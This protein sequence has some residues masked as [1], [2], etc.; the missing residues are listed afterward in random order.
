MK[1]TEVIPPAGATPAP[2]DP[3]A[4][5]RPSPAL[6]TRVG[7]AARPIVVPHVLSEA[8]CRAVV[9]ELG[10]SPATP[11][12]VLR[13]GQDFYEPMVRHSESCLPRGPMHRVALTRVERAAQ[14]HW[15]GDDTDPGVLSAAHYFRYPTGGFVAP[16]RDRSANQ[17]DPR[18]VQRR[19]ASLVLFLNSQDTPKGFEGGSLVIYV[20][21]LNGP[22]VSHTLRATAGTLVMFDPGL[23][24]E[25]TR[26]QNGSRFTLVA[27]LISQT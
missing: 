25:V 7:E 8:E 20:P 6:R 14:G 2:P 4:P 5:A 23:M 26:V 19:Q 15:P 1:E 21:Q 10:G 27:W 3:S 24:H 22:T 9:A 13:A 12:A 17:D 16:H 18:E 11:T